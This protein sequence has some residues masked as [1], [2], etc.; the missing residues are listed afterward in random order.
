MAL[1]DEGMSKASAER[2]MSLS[3][4]LISFCLFVCMFV[5]VVLCCVVLQSE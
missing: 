3:F 5:C 1:I 4:W 2:M